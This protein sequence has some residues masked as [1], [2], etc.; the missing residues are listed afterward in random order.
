MKQRAKASQGIQRLIEKCREAFRIP[1][2][3]DHYAEEDFRTA[4]RKFIKNACMKGTVH[5]SEVPTPDR[6]PADSDGQS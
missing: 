6:R 5:L 2:N 4:E 3:T 1:E